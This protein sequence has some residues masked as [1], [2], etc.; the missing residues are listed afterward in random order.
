[1]TKIAV[2]VGYPPHFW[3]SFN[4]MGMGR[5][6]FI[7]GEGWVTQYLELVGDGLVKIFKWRRQ[8][9]RPIP[10]VVYGLSLKAE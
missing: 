3:P 1:M 8:N 2:Q 10:Q 5:S 4:S 6:I 9:D 7:R